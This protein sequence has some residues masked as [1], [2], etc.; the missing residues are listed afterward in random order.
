MIF[1]YHFFL[2]FRLK[3]NVCLGQGSRRRFRD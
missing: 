2:I 3:N 1:Y